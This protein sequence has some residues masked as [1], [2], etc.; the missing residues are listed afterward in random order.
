MSVSVSPDR[1]SGSSIRKIVPPDARGSVIDQ[2][3]MGGDNLFSN[4]KANAGS[5]RLGCLEQ[6]EHVDGFRN[7]GTAV[8]DTDAH[9]PRRGK[10]GSDHHLAGN[11]LDRLDR[12]L[13]QVVEHA[14]QHHIVRVQER[15]WSDFAHAAV[16]CHARRRGRAR[17]RR[18]SAGSW[19]TSIGRTSSRCSRA[20]SVNSCTSFSSRPQRLQDLLGRLLHRRHRLEIA[21]AGAAQDEL[22]LHRQGRQRVAEVVHDLGGDGADVGQ[23]GALLA[24]HARSSRCSRDVADDGDVERLRR[25]RCA[26]ETASS[27]GKISPF[28]RCA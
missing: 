17:G 23:A 9:F 24:P 2:S 6:P 3:S 1:C 14:A 26:S 22:R 11:V 21:A 8:L 15:Q 28:L 27:I 18:T 4:G 19:P 12:V 20:K 7:S 13:D 16:G 25:R 10:R 5:F